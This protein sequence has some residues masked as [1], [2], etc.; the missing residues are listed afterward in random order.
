[1]PVDFA[2]DFTAPDAG[3]EALPHVLPRR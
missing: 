2:A 1:M 3:F